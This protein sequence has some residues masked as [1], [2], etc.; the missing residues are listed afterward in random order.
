MPAT[1]RPENRGLPAR[2]RFHHGAYVYRVPPAQREAWGGKTQVL[3][4][5]SLAEAQRAWAERSAPLPAHGDTV[6]DLLDAYALRVVPT[7]APTTQAGY[8]V[9]MRRLRA[10]L[11]RVALDDVAPPL[12]YRYF[13]ERPAKTAARRELEVLR[14]ALTMAVQW[15]WIPR[16][17]F[18]GEVRLPHAAPRTR[19]VEDWEVSE[20]LALPTARRG[21][22]TA[23]VQAYIRLKLATGL[24]RGDLLRLRMEQLREDGLHVQPHKTLHSTGRRAVYLWTPERRAAVEACLAVRPRPDVQWLFCTRAGRPYIDSTSG[25]AE[26]WKSLWRRFLARVL[27][28]TRV[29][30]PFTEHD[31]RAKVASDADSL[32]HARQLLGHADTAITERVYRRRP[33]VIGPA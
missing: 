22:A 33:E 28:E 7:R 13:E 26:A 11:G 10:V 32:E 30:E 21:D 14:H 19:Y 4:G 24:R 2:W 12:V 18:K 31:L 17:P 16:H 25:A 29:V 1:R 27:A 20:C 9:A 5:R 8:R 15:G 6:A 23:V 3:L